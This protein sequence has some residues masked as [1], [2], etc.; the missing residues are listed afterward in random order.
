MKM[1]KL[2]KQICSLMLFSGLLLTAC[3]GQTPV[4]TSSDAPDSSDV[5]DVSD[6]SGTESSAIPSDRKY[7]LVSAGKPY[8]TNVPANET[9]PDLFGQQLTDGQKMP[10]TGSFYRDVRMVGYTS[11]NRFDIDLGEDGKRICALSARA[12]DINQDG[13][14]L[15]ASVRFY[16]SN[17]KKI[18]DNLGRVR[19]EPT[20]EKTISTAR[21]ELEEVKDYRYIRMS[22]TIKS[23]SAFY[24]M[25][26]LEVFADV[27]PKGVTSTLEASYQN[28]QIDR[29]EW[30]ALSTGTAAVYNALQNVA[31]G[32]AYSFINAT[33]DPRA[34]EAYKIDKLKPVNSVTPPFDKLI[35]DGSQT[36]RLLGEPVWIGIKADKASSLK[37]D[38]S[39]SY[40]NLV[41]FSLHMIQAE[42]EVNFPDYVDVYGS[43]DDKTY[44]LLGRMYAPATKGNYAY[45]LI[46][47]EFIKA[48]YIRFD[49]PEGT[50]NY[51]I[52]EAEVFSGLESEP[53]EELYPLVSFPKV[54]KD[55]FWNS[56]ESDYSKVQN[57]I[58]GKP[59][60]VATSYFMDPIEHGDETA[61]N[62][63]ILTDGKRASSDYCYNGEFFFLRGGGAADFFFDL[64]KIS[65]VQSF[66]FKILENV[67]WGI[68]KPRRIHI[69]LSDNAKD[70]YSVHNMVPEG[71]SSKTAAQTTIEITLD[72]AYAARFVRIRI[73]SGFLF[74]DEIELMGT[75]EVKDGTTR[76]ADSGITP[77]VYY[78]DEADRQYATPDNTPVKAK[79]IALVFGEQGDENYLL[80]LVAYL[81]ENGNIKDT[82]MDGFLYCPTGAMPSGSQ[83]HLG[84]KKIDWDFIYNNTF[85]GVN[86]FDRLEEVVGQVKDAL[87]KPDYKVQAYITILCPRENVTDFG[88]VDGD[89][90]T[91]SLATVEGRRKVV[92]W[93]LNSVMS[94]F[95]KRNYKNLEFGGFYWVNEAIDYE[96]DDTHIVREVADAVHDIGSYLLWIPYYNANR[97][98]LGYELGFDLICMQPNYAFDL[99]QHETRF[100]STARRMKNMKMCLE[101]ENSFQMISDIRYARNY[102]LYL[103]YGAKTGYMKDATH[104]YYFDINNYELLAY[105]EDEM[106]RMQYDATH[107]F[108]K[109]TLNVTPETKKDLSF[110]AQKDTMLQGSLVTDNPITMYTLVT[111]PKHGYVSLSQ[112]GSFIYYPEKGYTGEDSF[113]YTYNEL[114]GESA[115]CKVTLTVK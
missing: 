29:G 26:E 88:D 98:F 16:G 79:D 91:E 63:T 110:D 87:N 61:G 60:Q 18:W 101:I 105:S 52:E 90:V 57:L 42:N 22:L 55:L 77:V 95:E 19:F 34:E 99:R 76:L 78:T 35:T 23:G 107:D 14:M 74:M 97:Y 50:G 1:K 53:E 40:D 54:D 12:L 41:K 75:K 104:I 94:E 47:P 5:S 56:T 36:G 32:K 68:H 67:E 109:G 3:A 31:V 69:L 106:C 71:D 46:M 25:D 7:T 100:T 62:T 37:I 80:P 82:F 27:P 20:G 49:F 64:E 2:L 38:L 9:Y 81:D 111:A 33:P 70:W 15:A 21:L 96:N 85:N 86:G 58:L 51:W 30:K 102:M 28:E 66:N 93:Y 10:D 43:A 24:F 11:S 115:P 48:Q 72:K 6:V 83:I 113:T 59:Q 4:D 13:V 45:T 73:E 108:I 92:D 103:Y 65:T 8:T 44:A 17:D 89:G 112:D 39:K 84:T 114:L